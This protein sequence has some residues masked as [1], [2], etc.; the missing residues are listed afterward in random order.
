MCIDGKEVGRF[1]PEITVE[2][3][4]FSPDGRHYS[5]VL[6]NMIRKGVTVWVDG[7]ESSFYRD[8]GM[9]SGLR[10]PPPCWSPKGRHFAYPAVVRGRGWT[11]VVDGREIDV[12]KTSEN[13]E[14]GIDAL[15]FVS[16]NELGYYRVDGSKFFRGT[17]KLP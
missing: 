13:N 3:L 1:P 14:N 7:R 17:V 10:N 16:E 5:A 15:W 4:K 9:L 6:N 8:F 12:P 11:I 2:V